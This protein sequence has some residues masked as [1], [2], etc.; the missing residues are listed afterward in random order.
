[1][2]RHPGTLALILM[3]LLLL[4]ACG[5]SAANTGDEDGMG[6]AG[7]SSSE[8]ELAPCCDRAPA[9]LLAQIRRDLS[10]LAVFEFRHGSRAKGPCEHNTSIVQET[11]GPKREF[12]S[13]C[14]TEGLRCMI[15]PGTRCDDREKCVQSTQSDIPASLTHPQPRR[16]LLMYEGMSLCIELTT[17]AATYNLQPFK[18]VLQRIG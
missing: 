2:A 7:A 10:L 14:T 4:V 13:I 6:S 12:A 1:M 11:L 18:A 5:V 3:L 15:S 16:A 9:C 17:L 8:T